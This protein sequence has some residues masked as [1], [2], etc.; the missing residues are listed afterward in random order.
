MPEAQSSTDPADDRSTLPDTSDQTAWGRV[1]G[2]YG[3]MESTTSLGDIVAWYC[4]D[5]HGPDFQ[6]GLAGP[7]LMLDSIA[8]VGDD[9]LSPDLS[10]PQDALS[11]DPSP[12]TPGGFR[13]WLGVPSGAFKGDDLYLYCVSHPN[14]LTGKNES[15]LEPYLDSTDGLDEAVAAFNDGDGIGQA[16]LVRTIS[17]EYIANQIVA[18]RARDGSGG[19]VEPPEEGVEQQW[20]T[21]R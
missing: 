21:L 17:G 4:P 8:C 6:A 15:S 13:V 9:A 10:L 5:P 12:G 18:A 11:E 7:F 2:A 19:V 1:L 3:T 16:I 20:S 14:G